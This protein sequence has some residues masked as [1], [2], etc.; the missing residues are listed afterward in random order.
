MDLRGLAQEKDRIDAGGISPSRSEAQRI[1]VT[2]LDMPFFSMVK[3]MV[4]W[5]IAS[6]PAAIILW[7][8]VVALISLLGGLRP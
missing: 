3:F 1:V 8:I 2:D 4:K 7:F 6:I 5:A